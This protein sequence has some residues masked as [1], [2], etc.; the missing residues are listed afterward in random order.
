MKLAYHGATHMPSSLETDVEV[1]NKAGFKAL[2]VW[3]AKIDKFLESNSTNALQNLF[4]DNNVEPTAIN[5]IEFIGFRGDEYPKIQDRCKQLCEIGQAIG[6]ESLVVV[7]S[8]TPKA[9]GDSVLELFF[10]WEKIV[11]EYVTVLN[12]LGDIAKPCDVKLAFEFIGFP[13]CTVRTPRGAYEIIRKTNHP[14]VAMNLDCCHF[15][16]GGGEMDEINAL[17]PA[18]I[19][20]FHLNDLEDV[21]KEAITDSHRLQPGLGVID[22][23]EICKRVKAIGYDGVCAIELFRKEYWDWDP[24]ELAKTTKEASLKILTKFFN[25][26]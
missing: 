16:G 25:V 5:S 19:L 3:A 6:C 11:D 10:P 24:L 18:K 15:Y 1:S 7:P 23:D 21:P 20:T 9:E 13:W 8:P 14:N 22:L 2:E 17:D 4:K 12:S 26:E